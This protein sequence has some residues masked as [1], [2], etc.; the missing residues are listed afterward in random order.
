M[1]QAS[2]ALAIFT[3]IG[4]LR[5]ASKDK[6]LPLTQ[7]LITLKED[8]SRLQQVNPILLAVADLLRQ[9]QETREG[10]AG[11]AKT[12]FDLQERIGKLQVT[13]D[14]LQ[15]RSEQL[16]RAAVAIGHGILAQLDA[17]AATSPAESTLRL[18]GVLV[19]IDGER[20][21]VFASAPGKPIQMWDGQQLEQLAGKLA[22]ERDAIITALKAWMAAAGEKGAPRIDPDV[23]ELSHDPVELAGLAEQHGIPAATLASAFA[24]E[25]D[26]VK[27]VL[28]W[29]AR[30]SASGQEMPKPLQDRVNALLDRHRMTGLVW[31]LDLAPKDLL[32]ATTAGLGAM[33][34]L[35][36]QL[37]RR[38]GTL[39]A[40]R[41]L[42]AAKESFSQA[43]AAVGVEMAGMTE[44]QKNMHFR[45]GGR[46]APSGLRLA[47]DKS[48]KAQNH[49]DE[50]E[51][52]WHSH[53][54]SV[55]RMPFKQAS[56]Q[57]DQAL[58]TLQE[59]KENAPSRVSQ[60][61]SAAKYGM[62]LAQLES[63]HDHVATQLGGLVIATRAL[64]G[65]SPRSGLGRTIRGTP[66]AFRKAHR[67]YNKVLYDMKRPGLSSSEF[68][69]S[70][71][72]QGD[73]DKLVATRN[74]LSKRRSTLDADINALRR[75]T[76]NYQKLADIDPGSIDTD[77]EKRLLRTVVVEIQ[78]D[79]K[80]HIA[81]T[82]IGQ[83]AEAGFQGDLSNLVNGPP[84]ME[85]LEAV[86]SDLSRRYTVLA[87][88]AVGDNLDGPEDSLT[89][90]EAKRYVKGLVRKVE[91]GHLL[92]QAELDTAVADVK[93]ILAD[94]PRDLEVVVNMLENSIEADEALRPEGAE[95]ERLETRFEVA[96]SRLSAFD[97]NRTDQNLEAL[98]E[99]AGEA[100]RDFLEVQVVRLEHQIEKLEEK[101]QADDAARLADW[102][103]QEKAAGKTERNIA[104]D[105]E[106]DHRRIN[107]KWLHSQAYSNADNVRAVADFRQIH[108]ELEGRLEAWNAALEGGRQDKVLTD[109]AT[110]LLAQGLSDAVGKFGFTA[111]TRYAHLAGR[112][113]FM[114]QLNE[115]AEH[116][117]IWIPLLG[118][119]YHT[120]LRRNISDELG[121]EREV[122]HVTGQG[123]AFFGRMQRMYSSGPIG[124]RLATEELGEVMSWSSFHNDPVYNPKEFQTF[125]ESTT[126]T[127]MLNEMIIGFGMDMVGFQGV[128]SVAR[129]GWALGKLAV[130]NL[131]RLRKLGFV[132]QMTQWSRRA[133][134]LRTAAPATRAGR[135][136]GSIGEDVAG[137]ATR[138]AGKMG[139]PGEA[140]SPVPKSAP[141]PPPTISEPPPAV[142]ASTPAAAGGGVEAGQAVARGAAPSLAEASGA[143]VAEGSVSV[144][145]RTLA[146]VPTSVPAT[147]SASTSGAAAA[148][149]LKGAAPTADVVTGATTVGSTAPEG[150]A[151]LA[152]TTQAVQQA[153]TQ[154]RAAGTTLQKA[155][156]TAAVPPPA[157][158]TSLEASGTAVEGA[159]GVQ[160]AIQ[161]TKALV[162]WVEANAARVPGMQ[163]AAAR[164][165]LADLQGQVGAAVRA[166]ES[167]NW[168]QLGKVAS[169]LE[170]AAARLEATVSRVAITSLESGAAAGSETADAIGTATRA[171]KGT[172]ALVEGGGSTVESGAT[173][174]T[175]TLAPP[176]ESAAAKVG[177]KVPS[178]AKT[179][180]A[181]KPPPAPTTPTTSAQAA[182]A[183]TAAGAGAKPPTAAPGKLAVP[184]SVRLEAAAEAT[185][186]AAAQT[187]AQLRTV[188]STLQKAAGRGGAGM[189]E[190][191]AGA[192]GL[193][194]VLAETEAL[195]GWIEASAAR[196]PGVTRAAA[197]LQGE[198]Q[199]AVRAARGGDLAQLHNVAARLEHIA[200]RLEGAASRIASAQLRAGAAATKTSGTAET[201][202]LRG[203]GTV[204]DAAA[205][206]DM[207]LTRIANAGERL[208]SLAK[209]IGIGKR[210][211]IGATD[212][213]S[214]VNEAG[215]LVSRPALGAHGFYVNLAR[216][217]IHSAI[218]FGAMNLVLYPARQA[219]T[220][221]W[222]G[223]WNFNGREY[224]LS[225]LQMARHGV[226]IGPLLSVFSAPTIVFGYGTRYFSW[227]GAR[228][229]RIAHFG[230]VIGAISGR[231]FAVI[232]ATS[233]QALLA[234]KGIG[235]LFAASGAYLVHVADI[236]VTMAIF[237]P[238]WSLAIGYTAGLLSGAWD[239]AWGDRESS[240]IFSGAADLAR[241][242]ASEE[243]RTEAGAA[244][245]Q[246]A[247]FLV[248]MVAS[249]SRLRGSV[250]MRRSTTASGVARSV[251]GSKSEL[252]YDRLAKTE[253]IDARV[254]RMNA[255]VKGINERAGYELIPE[256]GRAE[257]ETALRS[258]NRELYEESLGEAQGEAVAQL[259]IDIAQPVLGLSRGETARERQGFV[260]TSTSTIEALAEAV[261]GTPQG[262]RARRSVKPQMELLQQAAGA[263]A[264]ELVSDPSR[265]TVTEA[266]ELTRTVGRSLRTVERSTETTS[267][268]SAEVTA[269]V[270]EALA[271]RVRDSARES[272]ATRMSREVL[273]AADALTESVEQTQTV[274]EKAAPE[275][276]ER[277]GEALGE[278]LES[279]SSRLTELSESAA[280][281][282]AER[283]AATARLQFAET[284]L[285]AAA[286][287]NR[288]GGQE[289]AVAEMT[290]AV[291]RAIRPE[292]LA[293][294]LTDPQSAGEAVGLIFRLSSG[295]RQLRSALDAPG[296]K[297][298]KGRVEALATQLAATLETLA[299]DHIGPQ[300]IRWME[301]DPASQTEAAGLLN[302]I[303]RALV[304]LKGAA[305]PEVLERAALELVVTVG[306]LN[307]E[308]A[309]RMPELWA[310]GV[311]R[312][313]EVGAGLQHAAE[314]LVNLVHHGL[315][316]ADRTEVQ[317]A[318]Q[319]ILSTGSAWLTEA[320]ALQASGRLSRAEMSSLAQGAGRVI[321]A[322]QTLVDHGVLTAQQAGQF[323][324]RARVLVV[325]ALGG[326]IGRE[327]SADEVD[328]AE[329]TLSTLGSLLESDQ[330]EAQDSQGAETAVVVTSAL[331]ALMD[332]TAALASVS[333]NTR[334]GLAEGLARQTAAATAAVGA[335]R[336]R[337]SAYQ[338]A[339]QAFDLLF[340]QRGT[341]DPVTPGAR[342]DLVT[343]AVNRAEARAQEA[344]NSRLPEAEQ[345]TAADR[346]VSEFAVAT[347]MADETQAVGVAR[348]ARRLFLEEGNWG[349]LSGGGRGRMLALIH[350]TGQ[351]VREEADGARSR[352]ALEAVKQALQELRAELQGKRD[353]QTAKELLPVVN[354]LIPAIERIE[355]GDDVA[356]AL[357]V[358]EASAAMDQA[359]EEEFADLIQ[360]INQLHEAGKLEEAGERA[361]RVV[362]A[363]ML[364]TNRKNNPIGRRFEIRR[365]RIEGGERVPANQTARQFETLRTLFGQKNTAAILRTGGGKTLIFLMLFAAEANF[366]RPGRSKVQGMLLVENPDAIA[367]ML[368]EAKESGLYRMGKGEFRLDIANGDEL[369]E[370]GQERDAA[371]LENPYQ[372]LVTALENP[373][374][375]V[376]FSY[377]QRNFATIHGRFN[378]PLRAALRSTNFLMIDE[379]DKFILDPTSYIL[380]GARD[381]EFASSTH[382]EGVIRP[383][384]QAIE[385]LKQ[386]LT[387]YDSAQRETWLGLRTSQTEAAG[388]YPRDG[389]STERNQIFLNPK[390]I[391]LIRNRMGT[392]LE[393]A[394]AGAEGQKRAAEVS[395]Y[396]IRGVLKA[397]QDRYGSDY[398]A[399][400]ERGVYP[401]QEG[402]PQPDRVFEDL[403][404]AAALTIRTIEEGGSQSAG[405]STGRI[406]INQTIQRTIL[407]EIFTGNPEMRIVGG[408]ATFQTGTRL[409]RAYLGLNAVEIE[410]SRFDPSRFHILSGNGIADFDQVNGIADTIAQ[411]Q[412]L[413][414]RNGTPE[415]A[416]HGLIL[417]F[418]ETRVGDQLFM[419]NFVRNVLNSY[420]KGNGVLVYLPPEYVEGFRGELT[421]QMAIRRSAA[422]TQEF[423]QRF[424]YR[425]ADTEQ[426][427]GMEGEETVRGYLDGE[428][429]NF[430]EINH[431]LGEEGVTDLPAIAR[432]LRTPA[433]NRI[434]FI[435]DRARV[436]VSYKA[437]QGASGT[438]ARADLHAVVD[439][440]HGELI[441]QLTGR[442]EVGSRTGSSARVLYVTDQVVQ[443][444]LDRLE[445]PEAKAAFRRNLNNPF[446]PA[447][448]R[449][450]E[451]KLY[452]RFRRGET[453]NPG[454]RVALS[455]RF[456]AAAEE[457]SSIRHTLNEVLFGDLK[458]M[459][460]E[461]MANVRS[462]DGAWRGIYAVL[463]N[464]NLELQRGQDRVAGLTYS[465][466]AVSGDAW[467]R[468]TVQASANERVRVLSDTVRQLEDLSSPEARRIASHFEEPLAESRQ[469]R[470][471]TQYDL[472]ETVD[473]APGAT[474]TGGRSLSF[475]TASSFA[476]LVSVAK[477]LAQVMLPSH[478][479][480]DVTPRMAQ[481][482][483]K[484]G[485]TLGLSGSVRT[486]SA[487]EATVVGTLGHGAVPT[488][489]AH[490]AEL[491]LRPT[492]RAVNA[493]QTVAGRAV[494]VPAAQ[495]QQLITAAAE[496]DQISYEIALDNL[497]E[498]VASYLPGW[499]D[500]EQQFSGE[501]PVEVQL[502]LTEWIALS[503]DN[504]LRGRVVNLLDRVDG[505]SLPETADAQAQAWNVVA[506]AAE[507]G[508][509]SLSSENT[510]LAQL[511]QMADAWAA[512]DSNGYIDLAD[513]QP[514]RLSSG[515][516]S[517][518]LEA[519][520]AGAS[521]LANIAQ[522]I[523]DQDK[524]EALTNIAEGTRWSG[525]LLEAEQQAASLELSMEHETDPGVWESTEKEIDF[526]RQEAADAQAMLSGP[527]GEGVNLDFGRLAVAG[528]LTEG[529]AVAILKVAAPTLSDEELVRSYRAYGGMV[530]TQ[531]LA[532]DMPA[533]RSELGSVSLLAVRQWAKDPAA[534][535]DLVART[536]QD[537]QVKAAAQ[538]IHAVLTDPEEE[539]RVLTQEKLQEIADTH[540][541]HLS[542]TDRMRVAV[543]ILRPDGPEL[544][545]AAAR[546]D[547]PFDPTQA[548]YVGDNFADPFEPADDVAARLQNASILATTEARSGSGVIQVDTLRDV[549]W[550]QGVSLTTSQ[551]EG[552]LLTN[553]GA[554]L[555]LTLEPTLSGAAHDMEGQSPKAKLT[556]LY[557]NLFAASQALQRT[558]PT[559]AGSVPLS[560]VAEA[561]AST[562]SQ[563]KDRTALVGLVAQ[564]APA[565][566]DLHRTTDTLQQSL[567]FYQA[568]PVALADSARQVQLDDA[569]RQE[570][571][572]RLL[573]QTAS[574]QMAMVGDDVDQGA[575]DQAVALASQGI[576]I[577]ASSFL[578]MQGYTREARLVGV[579]ERLVLGRLERA[580]EL[581]MA[582]LQPDRSALEVVLGERPDDL[583]QALTRL[584]NE[585]QGMNQ[586]MEPLI[587]H[588]LIFPEAGETPIITLDPTDENDR[589]VLVAVRDDLRGAQVPA[590]ER[591]AVTAALI[592]NTQKP[593]NLPDTLQGSTEAEARWQELLIRALTVLTGHLNFS[594]VGSSEVDRVRENL[595][596]MLADGL[597]QAVHDTP[598]IYNAALA[599]VRAQADHTAGNI[600]DDYA[601]DDGQIHFVSLR[602]GMD[603]PGQFLRHDAVNWMNLSTDDLSTGAL[604][605]DP[606]LAFGESHQDVGRSVVEQRA[607]VEALN[608]GD[609]AGAF[610][611]FARSASLDPTG[612]TAWDDAHRAAQ[613]VDTS[614]VILYPYFRSAVFLMRRAVLDR[615]EE[616]EKTQ[617]RR[618]RWADDQA[619][620]DRLNLLA[621]FAGLTEG[622]DDLA[623]SPR[624]LDI[625]DQVILQTG[626]P[627]P[628]QELGLTPIEDAKA[629]DTIRRIET[630]LETTRTYRT[631]LGRMIA[632][633]AQGP[634]GEARAT[635]RLDEL[636][637]SAD[638]QDQRLFEFL[639]ANYAWYQSHRALFEA[640][641]P[642][643]S[644]LALDFM[645]TPAGNRV[646]GIRLMEER[647]APEMRQI[648]EPARQR[649]TQA[650]RGALARAQ[651]WGLDE[652]T[653]EHYVNAVVQQTMAE[654][655]GTE[656]S[657]GHVA[658]L[659][660]LIEDVMPLAD[661][662]LR[663]ALSQ[664]LE[665]LRQEGKT[666]EGNPITYADL[667]TDNQKLGGRL[668]D[669]LKPLGI[670][671]QIQ[672][673]G[674]FVAAEAALWVIEHDKEGKP[675]ETFLLK[676]DLG[677]YRRSTS[678]RA[679]A[680]LYMPGSETMVYN[681]RYMIQ[682]A[683]W[684]K[685]QTREFLDRL[686]Q[687]FRQLG[688]PMPEGMVAFLERT[689]KAVGD[690]SQ[691]GE[692]NFLDAL[693][694][695]QARVQVEERI[696]HFQQRMEEILARRG[697]ERPF[698]RIHR[699]ADRPD[700]AHLARLLGQLFA[701][702][703]SEAA[704][705]QGIAKALEASG[706]FIPELEAIFARWKE[707]DADNIA[708]SDLLGHLRVVAES[709][710][711][712]PH[713]Y[714]T[715]FAI[716]MWMMSQQAG[717]EDQF[718]ARLQGS[719]PERA[720]RELAGETFDAN[721]RTLQAW[722]DLMDQRVADAASGVEEAAAASQDLSALAE[723]ALKPLAEQATMSVRAQDQTLETEAEREQAR[724]EAWESSFP[725]ALR[726][727]WQATLVATQ[728][729]APEAGVD[730]SALIGVST[731]AELK[732]AVERLN[733]A[734]FSPGEIDL[735][736][737][738]SGHLVVGELPL[739]VTPEWSQAAQHLTP[740]R[741]EQL[742]RL[743][744][745]V[746]RAEGILKSGG[747]GVI[748]PLLEEEQFEHNGVLITAVK[749]VGAGVW[750]RAEDGSDRIQRANREQFVSSG[751]IPI[752]MMFPEDGDGRVQTNHLEFHQGVVPGEEAHREDHM[753]DAWQEAG[754]PVL[755]S[756]GHMTITDERLTF[757]GQP[758]GVSILGIPETE[759][760]R[761]GDALQ[762]RWDEVARTDPDQLV[763][764]MTEDLQRYGAMLRQVHDASFTHGSAH[765]DNLVEVNGQWYWVDLGTARSRGEMKSKH[766]WLARTFLDLKVA[767]RQGMILA[768]AAGR[769]R[770]P[771]GFNPRAQ[772]LNGYFGAAWTS[773][774]HFDWG[775]VQW[776]HTD[777]EGIFFGAATETPMGQI[778]S[779]TVEMLKAAVGVE[780]DQGVSAPQ[781]PTDVITLVPSG[782]VEGLRRDA[783][784][785]RAE[786][787]RPEGAF[788]LHQV[789]VF[790]I[791][792]LLDAS[793]LP[794]L[795]GESGVLQRLLS[796]YR[797]SPP[798]DKTV[799]V[800]GVLPV[801][802]AEQ[803]EQVNQGLTRLI[804]AELRNR[805]RIR[806][807][808]STA[809]S[810]DRPVKLSEQVTDALGAQQ[811]QAPVSA[812]LPQEPSPIIQATGLE[813]RG[814]QV[815]E[816][817]EALERA[818]AP[819]TLRTAL[820]SLSVFIRQAH[821][822]LEPPRPGQV[823]PEDHSAVITQLTGDIADAHDRL[824]DASSVIMDAEEADAAQLLGDVSATHTAFADLAGR[825]AKS[826]ALHG[827]SEAV[828]R[829]FS[830]QAAERLNR[831]WS[832]L[833]TLYNSV[834]QTLPDPIRQAARDGLTVAWFKTA[835]FRGRASALVAGEL[836]LVPAAPAPE[837][838]QTQQQADQAVAE[839]E[840]APNTQAL[841]RALDLLLA[842]IQE[843]GPSIQPARLGRL[844][845]EA[846]SA[847]VEEMVSGVADLYDQV[848]NASGLI[849]RVEGAG[850]ARL[851]RD[852]SAIHASFT[853]LAGR[854]VESVAL[855]GASEAT[856][857][858]FT[859][860]TAGR[861]NRQWST[862]NTFHGRVVRASSDSVRQMVQQGLNLAELEMRRFDDRTTRLIAGTGSTPAAA[863]MPLAV[864]QTK[865]YR[866]ATEA[867]RAVDPELKPI[868]R[869]LLQTFLAQLP[870]VRSAG[871]TQ[872]GQ[873]K[874]VI[875]NLTNPVTLENVNCCV[876]AIRS[877]VGLTEGGRTV[878][879]TETQRIV[880]AVAAELLGSQAEG[881]D[882]RT[883]LLRLFESRPPVSV[884]MSIIP[885]V[886]RDLYGYRLAGAGLTSAESLNKIGTHVIAHVRGAGYGHAA[887]TVK[888]TP[889]GIAP[890]AV[891]V[892]ESD[893][894]QVEVARPVYDRLQSGYFLVGAAQAD[895]LERQGVAY[896]VSRQ[897]LSKL[898][899]QGPP[900][901]TQAMSV[902]E[903]QAVAS[904]APIA[905]PVSPRERA[906]LPGKS[907]N[908]YFTGR[909]PKKKQK[910]ESEKWNRLQQRF[911]YDQ[912]QWL[913]TGKPLV[914]PKE[915]T[916]FSA[917]LSQAGLE[918]NNEAARLYAQF[919]SE[920]GLLAVIQKVNA[921]GYEIL[922]AALEEAPSISALL[923]GETLVDL[924]EGAGLVGVLEQVS[925]AAM[926]EPAEEVE[927]VQAAP[928]ELGAYGPTNF[929]VPTVGQLADTYLS[930][931]IT[932]VGLEEYVRAIQDLAAE[933]Y[934]WSAL[935]GMEESQ[936]RPTETGDLFLYMPN[937]RSE[938]A[939]DCFELTFAAMAGLE[940][941]GA[942]PQMLAGYND[943]WS[944]DV[945]AGLEHGGERLH[946]SF[947][948]GTKPITAVG[949]EE[950]GAIV[951]QQYIPIH[952]AQQL[953][954]LRKNF[955]GLSKLRPAS[956]KPIRGGGAE[957][958]LAGMEEQVVSPAL[959]PEGKQMVLTALVRRVADPEGKNKV[960]D[961][962]LYKVKVP[963]RAMTS[964]GGLKTELQEALATAG[965]EDAIAQ[966]GGTLEALGLQRLNADTEALLKDMLQREYVPTLVP[967]AALLP[968][969]GRG[970]RPM[971]A[972]NKLLTQDIFNLDDGFAPW[973]L[974]VGT[975][976]TTFLVVPGT[977]QLPD[978]AEEIFVRMRQ[979][980][981]V[982]RMIFF[983][984][985]WEG[986]QA[987][988]RHLRVIPSDDVS[989]LMAGL[990]E[991]PK[992]A[993]VR[994]LGTGEGAP[995]LKTLKAR[996]AAA[997][998]LS[999]NILP[1000]PL[1001]RGLRAFFL[1002][1003]GQALGVPQGMVQE[1004]LD[1005]LVRR[1006]L[1007]VER[1008]QL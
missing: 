351:F 335:G 276:S 517:A 177:V 907:W 949:L 230:G 287:L 57:L 387:I 252:Q 149:T 196:L 233:R 789:D 33:V 605:L 65:W 810:E 973:A 424:E 963:V 668:H 258:E 844:S 68:R 520:R 181:A 954:K 35:S 455:A 629:F 370:A 923:E 731:L 624:A 1002:R 404:Y 329:A 465:K 709:V 1006:F 362:M 937:G 681:T 457:S 686:P 386:E 778:Q 8:I 270:E 997:R 747:R 158:A 86:V 515:S 301:A 859:G 339:G 374:T 893:D 202:A 371:G 434:M 808:P 871:W 439:G 120:G 267:R 379:V 394:G 928:G 263:E 166:A 896:T 911:Q 3:G 113:A 137:Q 442:T 295:I 725:E 777:E 582:D 710:A 225:T 851:L 139:V 223:K 889:E 162:G 550:E 453:L 251:G 214:Y 705:E 726:P 5:N 693:H 296:M 748:V 752:E 416:R 990:E 868:A 775:L 643:L 247:F 655:S 554:L 642:D 694:A 167:G 609:S 699:S 283:A 689:I 718:I 103:K 205:R 507:N 769:G 284:A 191:A 627:L 879:R 412:V 959:G 76:A 322:V 838:A 649:V 955:V 858:R 87:L 855:H 821:S 766:E 109:S 19:I 884:P 610:R 885:P 1003:L 945:V 85:A 240:E 730:F 922:R 210:I 913:A 798:Q 257:M 338:A 117:S 61:A 508:F 375:L 406:R 391:R 674:E 516:F 59:G 108:G 342:H 264:V 461:S 199:A 787:I 875:E 330:F 951:P 294:L 481:A 656:L 717:G 926:E 43:T 102:T 962:A 421:R 456:L 504:D 101:V 698:V 556:T 495:E 305:N 915:L 245:S 178:G 841:Q 320:Q 38:E 74:A 484:R 97:A 869:V 437:T 239:W 924:V 417:V 188:G 148:T 562:T 91:G 460:Q 607:G 700:G 49:L 1005:A 780:P 246:I 25:P 445:D 262:S 242:A 92:T 999:L 659:G 182:A 788:R 882:Q 16:E 713:I 420:E 152:R 870:A 498:E 44:A 754:L 319:A 228:A 687:L 234:G 99:I 721:F 734:V 614:S 756:L 392:I 793:K 890:Q 953:V 531:G 983:G 992:G 46:H 612:F 918:D 595:S 313:I 485:R 219:I 332:S 349:R 560:E 382:I 458:G 298:L 719:D 824:L 130:T 828:I 84:Q 957:Y 259:A 444:N 119:P 213:F 279:V 891:T 334:T 865:A 930:S 100:G 732:I 344:Q 539:N 744:A 323:Q 136:S 333:A 1007:D 975:S 622:H 321:L 822:A 525:Q 967:P 985:R 849:I 72:R 854:A 168:A 632:W 292:A 69:A 876:A 979:P 654:V 678:G 95:W 494:A 722:G 241:D 474:A 383:L 350:Q 986:L 511:Y 739:E 563:G 767:A 675:L 396:E 784:T 927:A 513:S 829:R 157:A 589:Q 357:A 28:V 786:E 506:L 367:K 70:M 104:L 836:E 917:M 9:P 309:R 341:A 373:R 407:R 260:R 771:D 631:E 905:V 703:T 77:E 745:A 764:V 36:I 938:A 877:W 237:M 583:Q 619:L 872:P 200:A 863:P 250:G 356:E 673:S 454:E 275:R 436:G 408:S 660:D 635:D 676:R 910:R 615:R 704:Q 459:I 887:V 397:T 282:S 936:I 26:E 476:E 742:E 757:D 805:I 106:E 765:L 740:E 817:L 244:I 878:G 384:Y 398:M 220:F 811:G 826:L 115:G 662:E 66:E 355:R 618:F 555:L 952:E 433:Q 537:E 901:F 253:S 807:T 473:L 796:S 348:Q 21:P 948:P 187:N 982:N 288:S 13:H 63:R 40:V 389:G 883:L 308:A 345:Q 226:V 311:E 290:Q 683:E 175:A 697:D 463:E 932:R 497:G 724:T 664:D 906:A 653:Q 414:L 947:V 195:A 490:A 171:E 45:S 150:G 895:L 647:F 809:V 316:R 837:F 62:T 468:S 839:L 224:L 741:R 987:R 763:Q 502:G 129:N 217:Q 677:T 584:V 542:P 255:E 138:G 487:A 961:R 440:L 929:I 427:R 147:S 185:T 746:E 143:S 639:Q 974:A 261:E 430:V 770:L 831:Q 395:L 88:S 998:H 380:G 24:Q 909:K 192:R 505:V 359:F 303:A 816:A 146:S 82:V 943:L 989:A 133:V 500:L 467:L 522:G 743:V 980:A 972:E 976:A 256:K 558:A 886:V 638:S 785:F 580:E 238:L 469:F 229:E 492:C 488:A 931:G 904:A 850:A 377:N 266:G 919:S 172:A 843:V 1004:Q 358:A 935:A 592:H 402:A 331:V 118:K 714:G 538:A 317:Q 83:V 701:G 221:I 565:G 547:Q 183:D 941:Y 479:E 56:R 772:V 37:D 602:N 4:A 31:R 361:A 1000:F 902:A 799:V 215:A 365:Y 626:T 666:V 800:L 186:K 596:A 55:E 475:V 156:G 206:I 691:A 271:S 278:A 198:V 293:P 633:S 438:L 995:L 534:W 443:R 281:P 720:L 518:A 568:L 107:A 978:Q 268:E 792:Q 337:S 561:V 327:V 577:S 920:D 768:R 733:G 96:L 274:L 641:E 613:G 965:L 773:D 988:N 679:E 594:G 491:L 651:R 912:S 315:V 12:Y 67:A 79:E 617:D 791:Q 964:K 180:T 112:A 81:C 544:A 969:T 93:Q 526:W 604:L 597:V 29:L 446:V 429:R 411:E 280:T 265:S 532:L 572:G 249:Q 53:L 867:L 549:A 410:A 378:E 736:F 991:L 564:H 1001:R 575:I 903:A 451:L 637:N 573:K 960:V 706:N 472:V 368:G 60:L 692:Q 806:W 715:A 621:D 900:V 581:G 971:A 127:L 141:K 658:L 690:V 325:Q 208:E 818:P 272:D 823:P 116:W 842:L 306:L 435:N 970:L 218:G 557:W 640:E 611:H 302:Q 48:L 471:G 312:G 128:I 898:Q 6:Q 535:V 762:S 169:K 566:T 593:D 814:T 34:Q 324:A 944:N 688:L 735:W 340:E 645:D 958:T 176:A 834:I 17:W 354:E 90:L 153:N 552:Q 23:K 586:F 908:A 797:L 403:P 847:G 422:T 73:R 671:L 914:L 105:L 571:G 98:W 758:S 193:E 390:A 184:E 428:A 216:M 625:G 755:P 628:S 600:L 853:A 51:A 248:P 590:E 591:R 946:L 669:V 795:S 482:I 857:S 551:R 299:R 328:S 310:E 620:L 413:A 231:N 587:A 151:A 956:F 846:Y 749:L 286:V 716:A 30:E 707:E 569:Q 723:T 984:S 314:L 42:Q 670:L 545:T 160:A 623:R 712:E 536:T 630:A 346:A 243:P 750:E 18:F 75:L 845:I 448:V 529:Q 489:R 89:F 968:P 728:R 548:H 52:K 576:G 155:A 950:T 462:R 269:D 254:E 204:D 111:Q 297:G 894:Q 644:G 236:A 848:L 996:V 783:D 478:G 277:V 737:E 812:V 835:H 232:S 207:A 432:A 702:E 899:A 840:A 779:E 543:R 684:L 64:E 760:Q 530:S 353:T 131:P 874:P 307:G 419:E 11:L 940:E 759:D 134:G 122:T 123:D 209:P 541:S 452:L 418:D 393:E 860:Q 966:V 364:A 574:L 336:A 873:F 790:D 15:A 501:L 496:Q 680:W 993:T 212:L 144:G 585:D 921:A 285:R 888:T 22:V 579:A 145:G 524:R 381:G 363:R 197:G 862:L 165:A 864:L 774:D 273:P 916:A 881:A 665:Q 466:E 616:A 54:E 776:A 78:R 194:S 942:K 470:R 366:G 852:V 832:A 170:Q 142:P 401:M 803:I 521:L 897:H 140:T 682:D 939:A 825:S 802:S 14:K 326:M 189:P 154:L 372:E 132:Q 663:T 190:A 464:A 820:D 405:L 782:P 126:W 608:R 761:V 603:Q 661:V 161:E 533:V 794:A 512:S 578:Q 477:G 667:V 423:A 751:N 480:G 174:A 711:A 695:H 32:T 415:Q 441:A 450:D 650:Q 289:E 833:N 124:M 553:Q 227:L 10:A 634:Q 685:R 819:E 738:G 781:R 977:A 2:P 163:G 830:R 376:V 648:M 567:S 729:L 933:F 399:D 519:E 135:V 343:R 570:L 801:E 20:R 753:T 385:S 400:P 528:A 235:N 523:S 164:G 369:L 540:L 352:P 80:A 934:G 509:L 657:E 347:L 652:R 483:A 727:A 813:E 827:A 222:T 856:L 527:V 880:Q 121:S 41:T 71:L 449:A 646:R 815:A 499:A 58:I 39:Y 981:L 599:R 493:T 559:L 804:P 925:V 179:P 601:G 201:A 861:L 318:G 546:M 47:K 159:K 425:P 300:A 866:M 94:M 696:H 388:Y 503:Q 994:I 672:P 1008:R 426:L 173:T 291:S 304:N 203:A 50:L 510:G 447:E 431:E 360:E 7:D 114:E 110:M 486:A 636:S 588:A 708:S 514:T 1:Q 892:I 125:L 27:S 598:E 409:L 606:N 211:V